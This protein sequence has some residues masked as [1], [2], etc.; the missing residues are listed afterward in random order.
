MIA[1]ALLLLQPVGLTG[2]FSGFPGCSIPLGLKLSVLSHSV[3]VQMTSSSDNV[4]TLTL[5]KNL[6]NHGGPITIQIPTHVRGA[7]TMG[8]LQGLN[9]T[10]SWDKQPVT[11]SA[12]FWGPGTNTNAAISKD[13]FVMATVTVKPL[14][15]HALRINWSGDILMSGRDR[16][17]RSIAYDMTTVENWQSPIG[18][19][20]YSIQCPS[21][22]PIFSVISKTPKVGWQVGPKGAFFAAGNFEPPSNLTMYF[23]YYPNSY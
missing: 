21:P 10:A 4:Q 8:A 22:S 7:G 16:K 15:T 17:E 20:N 11:L 14:A 3:T 6:A 1:T 9:F 5:V 12:P 18:K 19:F 23:N 13:G 2:S